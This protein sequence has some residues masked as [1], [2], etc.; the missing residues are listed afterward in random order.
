MAEA[1]ASVGFL[2]L[3]ETPFI[4]GGPSNVPEAQIQSPDAV[5]HSQ[6][7]QADWNVPGEA[8]EDAEGDYEDEDE[9]QDVDEHEY[10]HER[11]ELSGLYREAEDEDIP[12]D[13]G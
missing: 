3:L 10:Q 7:W 2:D 11:D 1:G 9:E 4:E 5:G 6:P 12:D 8:D 13:I